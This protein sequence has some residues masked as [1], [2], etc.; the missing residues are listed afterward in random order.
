MRKAVLLSPVKSGLDKEGTSC[1]KNA[2]HHKLQCAAKPSSQI[3][4]KATDFQFL[5]LKKNTQN[6]WQAWHLRTSGSDLDI[7]HALL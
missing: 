7:K 4:K 5:S 3:N 1:A 2:L 6:G